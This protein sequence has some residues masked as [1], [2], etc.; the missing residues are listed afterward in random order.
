MA[1]VIAERLARAGCKVTYVTTASDPAPWTL[2]TL[3]LVHVINS[4]NEMGVEIVV[5]TS[6]VSISEGKV[7][8]NRLLTGAEQVRLADAVV[9]VTGQ[10]SDDNLYHE[11]IKKREAG[12]IASLERIGDCLGPGQIAQATRDGRKAG[13]QFGRRAR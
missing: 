9:L 12:E 2:N 1:T 8:T 6:I 5:G 7:V 4:M 3:E 11:L 13:M 10:I